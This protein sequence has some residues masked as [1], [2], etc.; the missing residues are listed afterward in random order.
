MPV[1][2]KK[3]SPSRRDKRRTHDV[4][5]VP[6]TGDCPKCG[7]PKQPHRACPNCGYY[8]ERVSVGQPAA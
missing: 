8:N 5:A 2:K 1:P 4:L 7:S 3:T 6:A